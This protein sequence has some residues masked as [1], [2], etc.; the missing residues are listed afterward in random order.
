MARRTTV[1]LTDIEDLALAPFTDPDRAEHAALV[2]WAAE[3]GESLSNAEAAVL[4][5]LLRAGAEALRERVLEQGYA[6]LAA[7]RTDDQR[8][9]SREARR[10]YAER[11][12]PKLSA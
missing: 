10:R 9:E 8:A 6:E 2:A 1:T 5:A 11:T 12:G 7:S 3:H 4:R